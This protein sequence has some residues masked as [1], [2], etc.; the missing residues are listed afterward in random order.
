MVGLLVIGR[1]SAGHANVGFAVLVPLVIG[2]VVV[3]ASCLAVARRNENLRPRI[4]ELATTEEVLNAL[5]RS[6]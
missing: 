2:L 6:S 5:G 1:P 3:G 4:G